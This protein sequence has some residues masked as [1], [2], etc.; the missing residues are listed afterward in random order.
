M[1][2]PHH[3]RDIAPAE[4]SDIAASIFGQDFASLYDLIYGDKNYLEETEMLDGLFREFGNGISA[5]HILD[6]GC[7]TGKHAIGLAQRGYRVTGIDRSEGM[8]AMAAENAA[9]MD[10]G[11]AL[12]FIRDDVRQMQIAGSPFDAA[13]MMFAVLG[14]LQD[15]EDILA[16]LATTRRHLDR[17]SLLVIDFWHGPGVLRDKPA[18]LDLRFALPDRDVIRRTDYIFDP[19]KPICTLRFSLE[20]WANDMVTQAT[21][22]DHKMRY[23]LGQE[24]AR[25][26]E[27][28]G[29]ECVALRD[30]P[31]W[32]RPLE[33]KSWNG[34]VVFRA[35]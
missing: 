8:L 34:I 22:E 25:L 17:H 21:V 9:K 16:M 2:L 27:A 35:V 23:F 18:N 31:K 12:R 1:A 10:V 7:G 3:P 5:G 26:G 30:F 20:V 4:R 14:Y 11:D 33:E 24:I 32:R 6:L 15:D 29:F 19:E 13:I 28:R